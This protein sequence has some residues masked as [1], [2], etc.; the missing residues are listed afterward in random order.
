MGT[1]CTSNTR[2]IIR[3]GQPLIKDDGG[4]SQMISLMQMLRTEFG[5][6]EVKAERGGRVEA[7][8]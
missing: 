4:S 7:G 1:K 2:E 8:S 5:L 3:P 6:V